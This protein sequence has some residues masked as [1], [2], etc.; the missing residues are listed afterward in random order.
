MK[1]L[2]QIAAQLQGYDPQALRADAASRF[3]MALVQPVE[4]VITVELKLALG[5]VLACDVGAQR[6]R[7][8]ALQLRSNLLQCS[9][10]CSNC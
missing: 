6:L 1:T 4:E 7:V 8:I 5:R 9:H 2:E 10:S 3:L